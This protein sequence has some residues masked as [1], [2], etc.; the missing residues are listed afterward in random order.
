MNPTHHHACMARFEEP[1]FCSHDVATLLASYSSNFVDRSG[2]VTASAQTLDLV[3]DDESDSGG[4]LLP[5]HDIDQQMTDALAS[6]NISGYPACLGIGCQGGSSSDPQAY[7]LSTVLGSSHPRPHSQELWEE[8]N[9]R[10]VRFALDGEDTG[11]VPQY[12]SRSEQRASP[13]DAS[14]TEGRMEIEA[15]H[16]LRRSSSASAV[17]EAAHQSH[18]AIYHHAQSN[19]SEAPNLTSFTPPPTERDNGNG[20]AFLHTTIDNHMEVDDPR[21]SYDFAEFMD[22]WR[23]RSLV[24]KSVPQFDTGIQPSVRIGRNVEDVRSE[25]IASRQVDIQG[26]HWQLLGPSRECALAARA[27]MHP[28]QHQAGLVQGSQY[29]S[30]AQAPAYRFRNFTAKHQARFS[31]YQLRNVLAATSRSDIFYADGSKVYRTA[32]GGI[33]TQD[34]VMDFSKV[35]LPAAAFRITCLSA[36]SRH[37]ILVAGGFNGEFAMLS[38]FQG[39]MKSLLTKG[40][41]TRAFNGLVTHIQTFDD[42]RSGLPQAAFCSNDQ[43]LRLMDLGTARLMGSHVYPHPVNC[44][45]MAPDGRLRVLVGDSNDAHVTDAEK[46]TMIATLHGHT[47]HGFACSWAQNGLNLATGAQDGKTLV[48]DARN[49]SRPLHTLPSTMSCPRSL[50]FTDNDGLIVAEDE[51]IVSVYDS[52]T[53]AKRQDIRFFGSIAGVA[54][55]DG[56]AELALANSDKTVGGLM[57]FQRTNSGH[58]QGQSLPRFHKGLR[59]SLAHA[60]RSLDLLSNVVV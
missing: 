14:H 38:S 53:F 34:T 56:G 59:Q 23:F 11:E 27:S 2:P 26:L 5:E 29:D 54:L 58:G 37:K 35:A 57:S 15:T 43:H 52:S 41:L 1:V 24:D 6:T 7:Q 48:W 45:A 9:S 47:D 36:S 10:R 4:V 19:D 17:D 12:D 20:H 8:E 22:T 32:L 46:G 50:H 25:D 60:H 3:E 51:D 40:F 44:S 16:R 30:E 13:I 42:R 18:Q 49:W 39:P 21:W 31:H 28:L 33:S 55:L